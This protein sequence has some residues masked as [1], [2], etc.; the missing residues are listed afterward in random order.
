[1]KLSNQGLLFL[2]FINWTDGLSEYIRKNAIYFRNLESNFFWKGQM[3]EEEIK[4]RSHPNRSQ[5]WIPNRLEKMR[6][7]YRYTLLDIVLGKGNYD[8]DRFSLS[9]GDCKMCGSSYKDEQEFIREM[10]QCIGDFPDGLTNF[11]WEQLRQE[12]WDV[13]GRSYDPK[14]LRAVP[15]TRWTEGSRPVTTSRRYGFCTYCWA[16]H[17]QPKMDYVVKKVLAELA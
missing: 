10:N 13:R 15:I 9:S 12:C 17:I 4:M 1:M 3:S 7:G 14:V 11:Q 2:G 8:K 16:N 6:D 5:N